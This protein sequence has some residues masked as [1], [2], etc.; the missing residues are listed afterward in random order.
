MH[1]NFFQIGC[2]EQ[3]NKTHNFRKIIFVA[4][5]LWN[6]I[7]DRMP[8]LIGPFLDSRRPWKSNEL[9]GFVKTCHTKYSAAQQ[10][11]P[12]CHFLHFL[13]TYLPNFYHDNEKSPQKMDTIR[14]STTER[15]STLSAHGPKK[16]NC[17]R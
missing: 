13:F 9:Q 16:F 1:V 15:G 8:V 5:S 7:A 10:T 3:L 17:L 6:S 2:S 12:E 14:D 4:S 11:F